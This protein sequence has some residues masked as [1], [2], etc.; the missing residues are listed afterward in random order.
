MPDDLKYLPMQPVFQISPKEKSVEARI[1]EVMLR[2]MMA[3]T[4]PITFN[5]L[6]IERT[7]RCNAKC[8]MCYQSAGPKGSDDLGN[9]ALSVEELTPVILTA[10][11]IAE[12]QPRFHLTGGEAFLQM[13]DCFRLFAVARSA[14]F[15]DITSTTNAFWART[16]SR[17]EIVMAALAKAGVTGLEVS[18]DIWHMPYIPA[19]AIENCLR[20]A[21]NHDIDV[22]LRL[23]TTRTHT[24]EEAL[25]PIAEDALEAAQRISSGP[26]FPSGRASKT[27]NRSDLYTQG[28]MDDNCHSFLNLTVSANGLVAPCCAGVDQTEGL[29]LGNIRDEPISE[30]VTR[31]QRSPMLRAL[32][33]EGLSSFL[34]ILERAGFDPEPEG[35]TSICHM[36]WSVFKDPQ[37][38][39][40]IRDYFSKLSPLVNNSA[41]G[42]SG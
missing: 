38:S 31:M 6:V 24:I 11:A 37:R 28:S 30:I 22:N 19:S 41:T 21:R 7:S 29:G 3:Q 42:V 25:A 32:V 39:A 15:F 14:G 8:A 26:V 35:H 1:A 18:W 16:P 17:A 9:V 2:R 36:C 12:V 5:A 10:G 33:F 27:L 40:A 23:L 13:D 34:P 20:A 4:M